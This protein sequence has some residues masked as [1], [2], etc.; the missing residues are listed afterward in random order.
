MT[1]TAPVTGRA[2]AR[3][4][5]RTPIVDADIHPVVTA[6]RLAAALP[7]PWRRRFRR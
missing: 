5:A 7:E 4:R 6:D 2:P 3:R 1:S